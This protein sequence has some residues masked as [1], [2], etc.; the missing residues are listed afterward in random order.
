MSDQTAHP[1]L[2]FAQILLLI[3]VTT[4]TVAGCLWLGFNPRGFLVFLIEERLQLL[5]LARAYPVQAVLIY[6]AFYFAYVALGVPASFFVTILCGF[7][8]DWRLAILMAIT[9][10]TLG[11]SCLVVIVRHGFQH[12]ARRWIGPRFHKIA[13]GFNRDAVSYLL[14][15]RLMPVFPFWVVNLVVAVLNV[16]LKLFVP[17]TFFGMAPAAS[18]AALIG[19]GLDQALTRPTHELL[20]CRSDGP[21]TCDVSLN[22]MDLA[23][24]SF[25]TASIIMGSLAILP[26]LWRYSRH[27]LTV[28]RDSKAQK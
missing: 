9:S 22:W 1:P 10:A 5:E 4:G 6:M 21:L 7:L 20:A 3:A 2:S 28:M 19:S 27:W 26:V 12:L 11:G 13:D 8:F 23:Q 14:F 16:P 18:A 24:P 25:V 15:M 17:V